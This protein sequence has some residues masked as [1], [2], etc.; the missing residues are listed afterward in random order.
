M[1]RV[2]KAIKINPRWRSLPY[3]LWSAIV[4]FIVIYQSLK[5]DWERSWVGL[6]ASFYFVLP[7]VLVLVPLQWRLEYLK[8]NKLTDDLPIQYP[9]KMQLFCRGMVAALITP[10]GGGALVGRLWG[11]EKSLRKQLVMRQMMG[12]LLAFGVTVFCGLCALLLNDFQMV[13]FV[14]EHEL[15]IVLLAI[16]LFVFLLVMGL[17]R[18]KRWS[19]IQPMAVL[20]IFLLTL[21]RF[22]IFVVQ[23]GALLYLLF[24]GE[25]MEL[26]STV[27]LFFLFTTLSPNW[28]LGKVVIRESVAVWL[29]GA[30]GAPVAGVLLMVF[31]L[32]LLNNVLPTG[33]SVYWLKKQK[34]VGDR[35]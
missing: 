19:T 29:F 25:L 31:L 1:V 17:N 12:Q 35:R 7:F 14:Q 3:A 30:A 8:W 23:L 5:I 15:Q 32:W 11:V 2:P 28:V 9:L 24:P 13:P 33:F 16:P 27:L 34:Y 26:V 6:E 10:G 4:L 18:W 20:P 21:L 22:F